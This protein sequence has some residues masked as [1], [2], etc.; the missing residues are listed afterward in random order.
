MQ[1]Q[2]GPKLAVKIA[3]QLSELVDTR[4]N[5]SKKLGLSPNVLT[6]W[7]GWADNPNQRHNRPSLESLDKL[8][9]LC[10]SDLK[11]RLKI[12][13]QDRLAYLIVFL[14]AEH[15]DFAKELRA[16]LRFDIGDK[17]V[18]VEEKLR[19]IM[20]RARE[21]GEP[22][23]YM[24]GDVFR[25]RLRAREQEFIQILAEETGLD[26]QR[27][28]LQLMRTLRD[29]LSESIDRHFDGEIDE[30]DDGWVADGIQDAAAAK[31]EA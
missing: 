28:R 12:S 31:K 8:L 22:L 21:D 27:D 25:S 3:I 30:D 4:S 6:Q 17:T 24:R 7:E 1:N 29:R 5:T 10:Q 9:R 14:A 2:T 16:N 20:N 18:R 11:S 23:R 15:P 26:S 19:A 13:D